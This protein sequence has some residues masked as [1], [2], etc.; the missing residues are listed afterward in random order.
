M[1]LETLPPIPTR[2]RQTQMKTYSV[3]NGLRVSIDRSGAETPDPD[4]PFQLLISL[5]RI[6]GLAYTTTSHYAEPNERNLLYEAFDQTQAETF[7]QDN[8]HM[9]NL[10]MDDEF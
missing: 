6:T 5:E 1:T 7:Y 4:V 3:T 9:L 2:G 10:M 8:L